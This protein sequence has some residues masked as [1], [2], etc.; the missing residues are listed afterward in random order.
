MVGRPSR[1]MEA[2][3]RPTP[4]PGAAQ[5]LGAAVQR[6]KAAS[7]GREDGTKWMQE[8]R[9]AAPA[10]SHTRSECRVPERRESW[11]PLLV[12][13]GCYDEG[14]ALPSGRCVHVP[15]GFSVVKAILFACAGSS[16]SLPLVVSHSRLRPPNA[17]G[18]FAY[19]NDAASIT[20]ITHATQPPFFLRVFTRHSRLQL[21]LLLL[22]T[23]FAFQF[24][25]RR[26]RELPAHTVLTGCRL[27]S[28]A[29]FPAYPKTSVST[30]I[31]FALFSQFLATSRGCF[32]LHA[33]SERGPVTTRSV[34]CC[35]RSHHP[36]LLPLPAP[37]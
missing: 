33:R 26:R 22:Q 34:N 24:L 32:A 4:I 9:H 30:S 13:G 6:S 23:V 1:G 12:R 31:T 8:K 11:M 16:T 18:E 19:P 35:T 20:S 2:P 5:R 7:R 36:P 21:L 10:P 15:A 37:I 3:C 27:E 14:A 25:H 28:T 29:I 17:L